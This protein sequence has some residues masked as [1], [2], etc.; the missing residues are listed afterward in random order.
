M[1]TYPE[2]C[3]RVAKL[4][5]IKTF[6]NEFIAYKGLKEFL[7]NKERWR[8]YTQTYNSTGDWYWRDQ[9]AFLVKTNETLVGGFL[10]V[11]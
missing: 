1:G 6:T 4:V 2:D 9:D 11:S 3:R 7:D 5:G 8:N 10:S